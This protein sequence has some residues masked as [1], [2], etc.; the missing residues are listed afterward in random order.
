MDLTLTVIIVNWNTR[1]LLERCLSSIFEADSK[2]D[3]EVVVVD[4]GSSDGSVEM[5]KAKF[6]QVRLVENEANLGYCRASNQAM[7]GSR[8]KYLL[9]LNSDTE[10]FPGTLDSL[11]DFAEAHSE[12]GAVG[13]RLVNPDGTL[14]YSCRGFPSFGQA[15]MH[16]FIGPL[17]P[18][19]PYTR[20]YKMVEW[21]HSSEREVDWISGAAMF[22][23]REVAEQVG[24]FD[25]DYFMYVEDVDLCYRLWQAGWKVYYFPK[26]R[27]MHHIAKS[28]RQSPGMILEHHR[29]LYHFYTKR[30]QNSYKRYLTSLVAVGLFVRAS[31]LIVMSFLRGRRASR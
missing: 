28:S 6:P 23:K 1:N 16:A 3:F 31:V 10:I 4:N 7:R 20:A 5:V 30:Y 17:F 26:A 21:D 12:V 27:V 11:V 9:L 19:N 15:I 29:S 2:V 13:P 25:E 14:Q 8:A 18:N 24:F 22:L